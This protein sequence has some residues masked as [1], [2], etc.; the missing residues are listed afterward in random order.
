M[1]L[2]HS[3]VPVHVYAITKS[4]LYNCSMHVRNYSLK[5]KSTSK[6]EGKNPEPILGILPLCTRT[7]VLLTCDIT[8]VNPV[9]KQHVR[10]ITR[11]IT[12]EVNSGTVA[13][14]LGTVDDRT[15]QV[16]WEEQGGK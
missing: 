16:R 14:G 2:L 12:V 8:D 15:L 13:D 7:H 6:C 5:D 11:P 3:P 4:V 10:D 1:S 9:V